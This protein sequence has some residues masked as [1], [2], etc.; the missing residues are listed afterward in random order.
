MFALVFCFE[1]E[2]DFAIKVFRVVVDVV[3]ATAQVPVGAA[4]V[5]G[6]DVGD[7][8]DVVDPMDHVRCWECFLLDGNH[9]TE[10]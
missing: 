8:V 6:S 3:A 9:S 5:D 7:A 1:S 4:I 2:T 10:S